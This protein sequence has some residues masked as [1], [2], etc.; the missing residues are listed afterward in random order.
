MVLFV[1][2]FHL[3]LELIE[4]GIAVVEDDQ[5]VVDLVHTLPEVAAPL[6]FSD[7]PGYAGTALTEQAQDLAGTGLFGTVVVLRHYLLEGADVGGA[8]P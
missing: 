6:F 3:A 8:A 1:I 4:G 5:D 7:L 2:G